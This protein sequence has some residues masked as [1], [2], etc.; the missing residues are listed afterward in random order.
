MFLIAPK[1]R[2]ARIEVGSGL[3][4]ALTNAE[5]QVIMDEVIVPQFREG[6]MVEGI[7]AGVS[8]IIKEAS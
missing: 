7:D 8:A 2:K 4:A 3:E 5:A 1:E 6:H